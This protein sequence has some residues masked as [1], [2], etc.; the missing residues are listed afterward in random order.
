MTWGVDN[1]NL[2][3]F[4][5]GGNSSGGNCNTALFFLFH[6]VG[7]STAGVALNEI[8]FVFEAGTVK[9]SLGCGSLA[10]VNMSNDT[11]VPILR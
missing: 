7:G 3:T 10:R 11:N 9:N 8:N 1:V 5:V 2:V 6:P 4:P